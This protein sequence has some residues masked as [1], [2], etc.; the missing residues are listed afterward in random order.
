LRSTFELEGMT[1]PELLGLHRSGGNWDIAPGNIFKQKV[2]R[3][4]RAPVKWSQRRQV[5]QAAN[6]SLPTQNCVRPSL[7]LIPVKND[8]GGKVAKMVEVRCF[9]IQIHPILKLLTLAHV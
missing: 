6:K 5:A 4:K 3:R 8:G 7:C 2:K 9:S 1:I